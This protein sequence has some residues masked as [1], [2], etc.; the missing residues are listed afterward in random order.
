M[1]KE[2]TRR[3][4]EEGNQ[5]FRSDQ[6]IQTMHSITVHTSRVVRYF[7]SSIFLVV[8]LIARTLFILYLRS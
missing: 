5:K 2:H 1:K 3:N 8:I 6:K 7:F 4:Q